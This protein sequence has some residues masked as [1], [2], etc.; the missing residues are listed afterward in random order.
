VHLTYYDIEYEDRIETLPNWQ[1]A[2][3]SPENY[4]LYEPYVYPVNQPATCVAGNLAT[5]DPALTRW[6]DLEGTRFAGDSRDCETVAVIDRGEQNVGSLF[7]TG[8]D[9]Q[10]SYDWETSIGSLR[11]SVNVAEIFDLDRSLIAGGDTFDI[12]DRIGWQISRRSNVRLNWANADWSAALTARIE[13]SYLN[14]QTPSG[15]P[16]Q[17]VGSWTTYDLMLRYRTPQVSGPWSGISLAL[18]AQ[19]V[20]DKDPPIVLNGNEA[21]DENVHNPFGRMWRLELGKRFGA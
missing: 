6:L 16:D 3:S 12:L 21:F 9:V 7:Q 18:G 10:V 20:T 13:G 14:D 19:N 15:L 1:T 4:A 2:F 11:A 5:Y 17:R 8:L